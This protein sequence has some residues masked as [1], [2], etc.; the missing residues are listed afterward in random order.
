MSTAA[1]SLKSI[2]DAVAGVVGAQNVSND[3]DTLKQ[4]SKDTSLM[5]AR[6]PD[7]V[8]RVLN[9]EQLMGVLK[10]AN[11]NSIPVVARSSGTGTY[12]TAIPVQGG[13]VI[14]D[15]LRPRY[16]VGQGLGP[17][18]CPVTLVFQVHDVGRTARQH[19]GESVIF[20]H[21]NGVRRREREINPARGG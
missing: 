15:F 21:F 6:M 20:P 17:E 5:P 12:G 14:T 19:E 16:L 13:A 4:Y 2:I 11:E 1:T 8:V 3:I 7:M 18:Y 10:I 9:R